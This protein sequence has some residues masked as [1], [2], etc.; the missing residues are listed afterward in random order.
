MVP[1]SDDVS[2]TTG[3]GSSSG[4]PATTSDGSSSG[5]SSSD[6]A[7]IPECGNAIV[8]ED[9]QCDDGNAIES[10]GCNP[11]CRLSGEQLEAFMSDLAQHDVALAVVRLPSDDVVIAGYTGDDPADVDAW[12]ARY[13]DGQQSWSFTAAGTADRNDI[14][15]SVALSPQ[16][17]ARAAGWVIPSASKMETPRGQI[18]IAEV[19]ID[20]GQA[21][22]QFED[23]MPEPA[24]EL[25]HGLVVLPGGDV[26][27]AGR[28]GAPATADFAVRRYTIADNAG[29]FE[30]SNVWARAFDGAAGSSDWAFGL[31]HD[32]VGRLVVGGALR[33]TTDDIDRHL[34]ALDL[35]G[36]P[37]E[38]ACE[39]FGS[40]DPLEADDRISDVAVAP[41]GAV[42]AVGFATKAEREGRD[43]WVG[44]YAVGQ[45]QLTWAKT[46]VGSGGDD[47]G[48]TAVAIDD[49]GRVVVGGYLNID[50]GEDAWLGKYD[51]EGTLLWE[52]EPV[53]GPGNG[54]DRIDD[55]IIG[56]E[57]EITVAGRMSVP[58]QVDA[59]VAR[60]T[61]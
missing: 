25:A 6:T 12:I 24:N 41:D 31:A 53:D 17:H 28:V 19:D 49:L 4:A 10:D 60:Y 8:E 39:D 21:R 42:A 2:T 43:L 36:D 61:P 48:A 26:V 58:G 47:D 46:R 18:W 15:T 20:D 3:H 14:A 55:V 44:Y 13:A 35:A 32:P 40:D 45:C 23:G 27:I 33:T 51:A 11:D 37:L 1:N 7:N 57:R 5:S 30:V 59:W 52:I 56:S 38:P 34:V 22:W 54:I 16:G 50:N 29:E 9:E